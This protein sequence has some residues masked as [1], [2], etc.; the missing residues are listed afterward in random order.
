[1]QYCRR[2]APTF[3]AVTSFS[4]WHHPVSEGAQGTSEHPPPRKGEDGNGES[5]ALGDVVELA[6]SAAFGD[7]SAAGGAFIVGGRGGAGSG[8]KA[9]ARLAR[10]STTLSNHSDMAPD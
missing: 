6:A 10:R 4:A 8:G 9:T 1:M 7:E 5:V 2:Y 3:A